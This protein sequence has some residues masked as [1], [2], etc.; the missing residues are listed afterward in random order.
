M[1]GIRFE[2][3]EVWE[4]SRFKLKGLAL[5]TYS[6]GLIKEKDKASFFSFM[7]VLWEFLI[8]S[9]SKDLLW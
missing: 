9:T 6:N 4:F 3:K 5:T 1:K 2:S 8:P 7:L